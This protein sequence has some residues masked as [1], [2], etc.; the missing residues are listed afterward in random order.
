MGTV[1]ALAGRKRRK[2]KPKT[3]VSFVGSA[4]VELASGASITLVVPAATQGQDVMYVG[5]T[6]NSSATVT[7]PAGFSLVRRLEN[8]TGWLHVFAA[9]AAGSVGV[10]SSDAGANKT[11]TQ[12]P[13]GQSACGVIGVYRNVGGYSSVPRYY[14][15]TSAELGGGS[16]P[17]FTSA[18]TGPND[19]VVCIGSS[20]AQ[21]TNA[22]GATMDV[23]P[24]GF[25]LRQATSKAVNALIFPKGVGLCDAPATGLP[26][27]WDWDTT[28]PCVYNA[29]SLV[30]SPA[31][32]RLADIEKMPSTLAGKPVI[33]YGT[34]SG[35]YQRKPA[36]EFGYNT[37]HPWSHRI[38]EVHNGAHDTDSRNFA[39]PGARA[40][41]ICVYL[42]GTKTQSTKA[43][44]LDALAVTQAGTYN[45]VPDRDALI[46]L[47]LIGNDFIT[48]TQ[49]AQQRLSVQNALYAIL[50]RIRYGTLK[51]A[52]DVGITY[53]GGTWN[54]ATT[55]AYTNGAGRQTT[56]PGAY[57][58]FSV[59]DV[60][61]LD[62]VLIGG[63]NTAL[64]NTGST[65][66]IKV[67]GVTVKSGTTHNQAK[68]TGYRDDWKLCQNAHTIYPGAG[69]H[70][71]RLQHTGSSGHALVF[72][73]WQAPSATPP[74]VV[75]NALG[76]MSA[77]TQS[78][79]GFTQTTQDEYR[80][81]L[82]DVAALF[83]DGRVM[84][85]DP[86]ASGRW[87]HTTHLCA[88]GVHQNEIGHTHYAHEIVRMLNERVP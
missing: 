19:Y 3:A 52:S 31:S 51:F 15:S 41:D 10:S 74:W 6:A 56:V 39:M 67:D 1:L 40:I 50:R 11:F 32:P 23:V 88:D 22:L 71:I 62:I 66:D 61:E 86:A 64:G 20:F 73:S 7:P 30:L 49:S 48:T 87:S 21:N 9:I 2:A 63:D 57:L 5:I 76:T 33:H 24:S 38:F 75:L 65:F 85:Y 29:V 27:L 35:C 80:Q 53:G 12:A 14:Q 8:G 60:P 69:T 77:A 84:V 43:P 83:P 78:T 18:W 16:P 45:T 68:A 70:T 25:T 81:Y 79:W 42:H 13:T 36:G 58:E 26:A 59:T 44:N 17:R 28:N 47:D 4:E 72:D 54:T 55:T 34:S 37:D 82:Y 46:L